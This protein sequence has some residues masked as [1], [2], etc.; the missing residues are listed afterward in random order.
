MLC[1]FLNSFLPLPDLVFYPKLFFLKV[2]KLFLDTLTDASLKTPQNFNLYIDLLSL[3]ISKTHKSKVQLTHLGVDLRIVTDGYHTGKQL[4]TIKKLSLY[5]YRIN[6]I[7]S[8][9]HLLSKSQIFL[10]PSTNEVAV[11]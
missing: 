5:S 9:T 3:H 11:R 1:H 7:R 6:F 10:L 2:S 8:Y 4:Y